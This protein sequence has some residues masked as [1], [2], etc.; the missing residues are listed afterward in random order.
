LEWAPQEEEEI[1]GLD[2]GG[3]DD[4]DNMVVKAIAIIAAIKSTKQ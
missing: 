2:T 4:N 1:K 3:T